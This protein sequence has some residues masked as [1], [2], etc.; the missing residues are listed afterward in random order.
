MFKNNECLG[1]FPS[2]KYIENIS[3]INFKTHLGQTQII[4]NCNKNKYSIVKSYKGYYFV[5]EPDYLEN[6]KVVS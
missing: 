3:E 4:K 5:F 2:T 1:T 6:Y